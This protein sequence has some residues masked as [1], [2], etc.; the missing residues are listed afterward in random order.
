MVIGIFDE[1]EATGVDNN[2]KN[3]GVK[4]HPAHQWDQG[5]QKKSPE[6]TKVRQP[7]P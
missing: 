6:N 7:K 4:G 2:G 5:K 3:Y 1:H